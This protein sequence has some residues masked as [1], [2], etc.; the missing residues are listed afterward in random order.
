MPDQVARATLQLLN[1]AHAVIENEHFV[2]ISGDHGS[3]WIDKDAIF[4]H[5][6]RIEQLATA[7][8][9]LMADRRVDV[10]CG[11]ATGGLVLAQWMGHRLKALAVFSEHDLEEQA[12]G[13]RAMRPPLVL[14]RGYDKLVAG[15]RVVVVDDI[16]NTGH[17][18][19]QTIEAVR[20]AGGEVV[21]AASL[22]TRG[23]VAGHALGVDRFEYLLEYK[24][25]AWPEAACM[26]CKE[27]RP[28]NTTYAH[29]RDY[30]ARRR[31][32]L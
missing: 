3:G 17:S 5:T 11:P 12:E 6:E 29:G 15:R 2:Y 9:E 30:L 23:N 27:G 4:P 24:I 22:V 14:R 21:A 10:V 20:A 32:A 25:A 26:L 7:L 16:V 8:A 28:I 31:S 18:I 19:R 13:R 1:D